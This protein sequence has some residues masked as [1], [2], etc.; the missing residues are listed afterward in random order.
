MKEQ[1]EPQNEEVG[2]RFSSKMAL[3]EVD[4]CFCCGELGHGK[5]QCPFIKH[6]CALCCEEGHLE[7]RCRNTR[8]SFPVK[9]EQCYCFSASLGLTS[10]RLRLRQCRAPEEGVPTLSRR[11]L[12]LLQEGW[13][14]AADVPAP[15]RLG[16]V[17]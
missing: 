4:G 11:Q 5:Q 7:R 3:V 14:L 8:P 9:G 17:T 1:L 10:L 12:Q 6:T 2:R 15:H 13:P 16:T